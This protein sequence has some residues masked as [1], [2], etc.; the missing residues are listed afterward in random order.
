MDKKDPKVL[1][2][3]FESMFMLSACT[4]GGGFVI[5]SLMKKKFV[6]EL[7]WIE[8]DEMLDITAI[9]QSSPGPL[10]VNASVIIGYRMYGIIG[11]LVAILGTII[12][13]MVIISAISLFYNQFRENKYIAI[14]LQVM[15]AGVA[16]V[17]LDVTINLAKNVCKTKRVMY[18]A[19]M[20]IAFISTYFFNVSAMLIILI[21]L[22]IGI[23][24]LFVS[25]SKK[26][27]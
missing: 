3:L 26:E 9:T 22:S 16:A 19:M 1:W 8:E 10:P 15:R 25:M 14:A 2:K 12:P 5:V 27:A 18:I 21:C 24:D 11:S 17:I 20:V 23:I 4:F 13:P 6:E 7:E